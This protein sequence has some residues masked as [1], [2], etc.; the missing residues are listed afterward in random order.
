MCHCLPWSEVESLLGY[1]PGLGQPLTCET[2]GESQPSARSSAGTGEGIA[3]AELADGQC[4][5]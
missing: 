2:E 5:A 4:Q 1:W 3:E